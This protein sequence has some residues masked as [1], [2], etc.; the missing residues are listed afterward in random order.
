MIVKITRMFSRSFPL[1]LSL[2]ILVLVSVLFAATIVGNT[3][4]A[5][6]YVQRE[7]IERA[8]SALDNTILR[9]N[10]VLHSVEITLNNLSWQVQESLDKPD[11]LYTITEHII[12]SNDFISGSAIAFEPYY[13]EQKG[14]YYSPYSYREDGEIK[15]KQLGSSEY[16]YHNM[17]WYQIPRELKTPYWSEAYYDEGGGNII[18]PIPFMIRMGE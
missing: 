4:S 6:R 8:Q 7:S 13:Y 14:L 15:S 5:R 12:Q 10:S 16:D 18:T 9:I 1:R 3:R 11:K 2:V 17:D